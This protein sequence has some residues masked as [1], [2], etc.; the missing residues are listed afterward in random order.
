MTASTV[1]LALVCL[2]VGVLFAATITS[3]VQP[4]SDALSQGVR[5]ML[6]GLGF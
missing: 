2:A 6:G 3:W 5:V 4:A 1:V